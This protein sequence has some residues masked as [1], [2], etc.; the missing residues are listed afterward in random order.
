MALYKV[1]PKCKSLQH[2]RKS[3]C[4][5]CGYVFRG[6]RAKKYVMRESRGKQTKEICE[7]HWTTETQLHVQL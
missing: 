7:S 5:D 1:C 6:K 4:K 3:V 2:Y